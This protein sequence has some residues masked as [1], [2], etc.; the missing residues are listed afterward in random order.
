MFITHGQANVGQLAKF[1]WKVTQWSKLEEDKRLL[2]H[3]QEMS[4]KRQLK[5]S[6]SDCRIHVPGP[7]IYVC[8]CALKNEVYSF[9]NKGCPTK[10]RKRTRQ[11]RSELWV[12][13]VWRWLIEVHGFYRQEKRRHRYIW[14]WCFLLRGRDKTWGRPWPRPWGRPWGRPWPTG[15]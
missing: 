9:L 3:C 6:R 5:K 1:S 2:C 10:A 8:R 11:C 4:F 15:G 14:L 12:E 7:T 13:R